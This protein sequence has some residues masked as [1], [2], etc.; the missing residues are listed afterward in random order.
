[1]CFCMFS[2]GVDQHP[3]CL[4]DTSCSSIDTSFMLSDTHPLIVILLCNCMQI[5]E[6]PI[7]RIVTTSS[8]KLQVINT[9]THVTSTHLNFC[10]DPF[11]INSCA[12]ALAYIR[13][14]EEVPSSIGAFIHFSLSKKLHHRCHGFADS[15][16]MHACSPTFENLV[17]YWLPELEKRKVVRSRPM[18]CF[19]WVMPGRGFMRIWINLTPF[20]PYTSHLVA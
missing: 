8:I 19:L 9:S 7:Q 1:M 12:C 18:L 4:T 2:D 5:A 6:Q 17:S 15:K 3:L 16:H 14:H 10:F 11:P 20:I 13:Y